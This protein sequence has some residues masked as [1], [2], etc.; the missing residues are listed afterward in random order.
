MNEFTIVITI[1]RP[2]DEVFAAMVDTERMPLWMPGASEVRLTSDGPLETGSSL[3]SRVTFLGRSFESQ[4]VCTGLTENKHFATK[5]TAG[6]I[7]LE[8][9]FVLEPV[10]EGTR[11]TSTFRGE[12]RGFFKLAEP[13]VVRLSKRYW[14]T[15]AENLRALLEDHAL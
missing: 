8:A 9:D 6:P 3:V 2:I 4:M 1:G 15:A 5:S 10:T 11:V 14:E 12:S 7:Y 13:L